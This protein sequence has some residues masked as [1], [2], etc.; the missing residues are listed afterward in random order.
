MQGG[1]NWIWPKT[2][3]SESSHWLEISQNHFCPSMGPNGE[4]VAMALEL[5]QF[6]SVLQG[7]KYY[8]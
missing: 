8:R 7:L 4:S 2:G 6:F 1:K 3:S 5:N